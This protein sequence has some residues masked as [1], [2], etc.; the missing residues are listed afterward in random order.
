M[1]NLAI[2]AA[3]LSTVALVGALALVGLPVGPALGFF[4]RVA[5]VLGMT[6]LAALLPAAILSGVLPTLTGPEDD[7]DEWGGSLCPSSPGLGAPVS[8]VS[9]TATERS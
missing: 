8:R 9:A 7:E 3:V 5:A 6:V 1:R 4:G 2:F